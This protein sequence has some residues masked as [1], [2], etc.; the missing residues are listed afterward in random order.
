MIEPSEYLSIINKYLKE[1][2]ETYLSNS[3]QTME[4]SEGRTKFIESWGQLASQWGVS[5]TMGH[6]HGLL[7]TNLEP[8]CADQIIEK[9]KISRGNANQNI[10]ALVDWSLVHKVQIEGQRKDHFVAQK[11]MWSILRAIITNRKR[12]ELEPLI[13]VLN[14]ISSV[15]AQC[16]DSDAF[17]KLVRQ[18]NRFSTQVNET[19]DTVINLESD[20]LIQRMFLPTHVSSSNRS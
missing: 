1:C 18:L 6:I 10:R 9:L 17:C 16:P 3:C 20:E 19:L 7:L 13:H 8:L 2:L 11:D 15:Q 5:R 12:K 14:D 4:Y